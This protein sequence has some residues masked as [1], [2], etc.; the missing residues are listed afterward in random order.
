MNVKNGKRVL[1]LLENNGYPGDARVR[2]EANALAAN[3]YSVAVI[4]PKE[5]KQ[6]WR[7]DVDGVMAYRF[8]APAEGSGFLGYLWEYGYSLIMMTIYSVIV[9]A[10]RGFDVI[11]AHNPPD[12]L[13]LVALIYKPF[14][15]KFI[16]DHH[17]LS[18]EMYNANFEKEGTGI[19]FNILVFFEKLSCRVADHLIA[20]NQSYKNMQI[21]RSGVPEDKVTIVRNGPNLKRMRLVD[22]DPELASMG[23]TIIGY[24]GEMSSHDGLDYLL[25]ALHHLVYDLKR[26]DFY[27]V[28]IGSGT[29]WD[30]L[31][32][33]VKELDLTDYVR[34]TGYISE[35][36]MLAYLSA[37]SICVDPDPYNPFNDRCTMI[38]MTEYMALQKPIVAFDLTE[39]R[40]TAQDAALYAKKNDEMDFA[41]KIIQLMDD[42]D[43]RVRMGQLGRVRMEQELAW[44]HQIHSLLEAYN[45][46]TNE[47]TINTKPGF[48][49]LNL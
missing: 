40:V 47:V 32:V 44:E 1:M 39:H 12:I 23:K 6:P 16:F 18:P 28:L 41:R 37:T 15:V 29:A 13:V 17:D 11:H 35:A 45:A 4:A 7:E 19:M 8:P 10:Q 34:L 46:L 26:T 20:T 9:L 2:R 48:S 49:E 43:T 5:G 31:N 42:S 33:L 38:K 25:R 14:G 21:E 22:P 36:D 24:V 27:A 30:S 3:G